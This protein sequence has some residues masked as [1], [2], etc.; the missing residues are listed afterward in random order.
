MQV[1]FVYQMADVIPSATPSFMLKQIVENA[2]GNVFREMAKVAAQ[3]AV[4]DPTCAHTAHVHSPK[5]AA[6]K[7][8]YEM[9]MKGE[10]G[11]AA[12]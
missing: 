2:M 5:M 10:G 4:D 1:R 6:T 8:W 12:F 9:A 7:R 3:M 11:L